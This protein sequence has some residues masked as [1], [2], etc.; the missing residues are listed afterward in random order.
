[1]KLRSEL[2]RVSVV[3]RERDARLGKTS[4]AYGEKG[5]ES[6]RFYELQN[7]RELS[8]RMSDLPSSRRLKPNASQLPVSWYFDPQI[9][10]LEQKL[11]FAN[12]PGYVG[13][14]LM[15]PNPGDYHTLAWM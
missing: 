4:G 8:S 6:R 7:H 14:E 1:M 12:S 15:V 2:R 10:E 11:L 9:F 3:Q 5:L 13:H